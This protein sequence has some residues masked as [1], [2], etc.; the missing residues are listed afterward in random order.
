LGFARRLQLLLAEAA[1]VLEAIG[2]RRAAHHQLALLLQLGGHLAHAE[3][4]VEHHHVGPVDLLLP[5]GG[6]RHEAVA[7]LLLLGVLDEEA[8]L[9][10]FL[11]HLPGDVGDEA[12]VG[13]E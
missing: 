6:L 10:A 7:D 5:V 13:N 3:H 11:H 9:M 8:G 12:G 2:I 1:V 4:V